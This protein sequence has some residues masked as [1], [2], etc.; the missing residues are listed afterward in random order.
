IA[1]ERRLF[2]RRR[3]AHRLDVLRLDANDLRL[4]RR[5]EH[6]GGRR[7]H[8][9]LVRAIVMRHGRRW[10]CLDLGQ[11]FNARGGRLEVFRWRSLRRGRTL[12]A[13][14]TALLAVSVALA[15]ATSAAAAVAAAAAAF[16]MFRVRSGTG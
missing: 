15:T 2:D 6:G 1:R 12:A 16:A 8:R 13:A 14:L 10:K 5:L 4:R 9:R 11:G 7:R 3:S